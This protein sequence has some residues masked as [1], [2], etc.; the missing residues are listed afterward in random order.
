[1]TKQLTD[2][3]ILGRLRSALVDAAQLREGWRPLEREIAKFPLLE[4]WDAHRFDATSGYPKGGVELKGWCDGH[5]ELPRGPITSAPV[6]WRDQ[7]AGLA[8]T[9][10]RWLRLGRR[11]PPKIDQTRTV[12]APVRSNSDSAI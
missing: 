12:D 11:L 10:M 4:S 2:D 5:P 7:E 8:R 9:E 3:Q 6:L 1:M